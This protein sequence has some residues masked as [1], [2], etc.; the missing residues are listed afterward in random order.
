MAFGFCHV[1]ISVVSQNGPL[2]RQEYVFQE[3]V[4]RAG[5]WLGRL[6]LTGAA[7]A[8]C[9]PAALARAMHLRVGLEQRALCGP[10][11]PAGLESWEL[12]WSFYAPPLGNRRKES[13][14][15]KPIIG[16]FKSPVPVPVPSWPERSWGEP[17]GPSRAVLEEWGPRGALAPPISPS[18]KG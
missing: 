9:R 10:A 6:K 15:P 7:G 2:L 18:T 8:Q 17:S 5:Q 16:S 12:A 3:R 13:P 4:R 1:G 11:E 14:N